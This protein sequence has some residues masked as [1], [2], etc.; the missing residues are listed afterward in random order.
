MLANF[1]LYIAWI[2]IQSFLI[3]DILKVVQ[4]ENLVVRFS[5]KREYFR[6]SPP[7][8]VPSLSQARK[9][10]CL[11]C[12]VPC[13][14]GLDEGGDCGRGTAGWWGG[15]K[16]DQQQQQPAGC[17]AWLREG[18]AGGAGDPWGQAPG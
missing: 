1:N 17:L 6:G 4:E 18:T 5:R 11:H 9:A 10:P 2:N 8:A 14:T 3:G 13:L 16:E 7:P 15:G 12:L